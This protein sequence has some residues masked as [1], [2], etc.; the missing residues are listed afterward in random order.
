MSVAPAGFASPLGHLAA[1]GPPGQPQNSLGYGGNSNP[2][3]G[4]SSQRRDSAGGGG[5]ERGAQQAFSPSLVEQFKNKAPGGGG[6]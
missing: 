5:G 2:L 1:A 4:L 6:R 3:G